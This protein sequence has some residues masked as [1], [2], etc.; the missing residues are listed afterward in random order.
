M[1]DDHLVDTMLLQEKV[2]AMSIDEQLHSL[3]EL[4]DAQRRIDLMKS[5]GVPRAIR[6]QMYKVRDPNSRR[7]RK[8][9]AR[10]QRAAA[11]H[12]IKL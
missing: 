1:Q 10:M 9:L 12:G 7:S 6:R 3:R 5:Q 11:K 4:A 8:E 2:K